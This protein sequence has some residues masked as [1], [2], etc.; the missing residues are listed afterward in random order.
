[1]RGCKAWMCRKTVPRKDGA[2]KFPV[3]VPVR[4]TARSLFQ[5]G[6]SRT[7]RLVGSKMGGTGPGR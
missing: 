1:M 2:L 4:T 3:F 5:A 7:S 6:W